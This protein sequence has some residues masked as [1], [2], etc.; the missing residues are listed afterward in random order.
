[1]ANLDRPAFLGSGLAA[2]Q[3]PG[4]TRF[5]GRTAV[6]WVAASLLAA[7]LAGCHGS[8]NDVMFPGTLGHDPPPAINL[9]PQDAGM[10]Y[11]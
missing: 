4:M 1:M 7:L 5:Y 11:R 10:E 3:R 8:P 2:A 9:P 6:K